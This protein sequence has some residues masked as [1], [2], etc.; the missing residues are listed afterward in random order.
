MQ[1]VVDVL[2]STFI[3][4]AQAT[5]CACREYLIR[6][7]LF[8]DKYYLAKLLAHH[9]DRGWQSVGAMS[10][11]LPLPRNI[12]KRRHTLYYGSDVSFYVRLHVGRRSCMLFGM[13]SRTSQQLPTRP[14]PVLFNG[15]Q[16]RCFS[17]GRKQEKF[18]KSRTSDSY[19]P[20]TVPVRRL[21]KALPMRSKKWA[22]MTTQNGSSPKKR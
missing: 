17:N 6:L 8:N 12:H 19:I 1:G 13:Q 14:T 21:E 16:S 7:F 4:P 3:Q 9:I 20:H 22:Q 18:K 10:F 15:L 5:L 2:G 11:L